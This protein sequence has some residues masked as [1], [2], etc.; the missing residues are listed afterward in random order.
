MPNINGWQLTDKLITIGKTNNEAEPLLDALRLLKTMEHDIKTSVVDKRGETIR[1][2]ETPEILRIHQKSAEI[3][4]V[5][6]HMLAESKGDTDTLVAIDEDS[7]HFDAP[8]DFDAFC[9]YMELDRDLER[10]F[11]FPRRPQLLPIVKALERLERG[12]LDILTIS[13]PPGTG[14]ALADD[15]PVL[16]RN[17]WKNHGDLVVGDE[18]VGLDGEWKKVLAVHPKCMLDQRV[19]FSNGESI[20]CH[21]AHE[22]LVFDRGRNREIQIETQALRRVPLESGVP[23]QRGHRY[24]FQLPY[25]PPLMGDDKELPMDPYTLGVWLGDGTGTAPTI[26][27]APKDKAVIDRIVA[28]GA[29]IQWTTTHKTTGVLYFG[30][31]FQKKLKSLG[32]CST[33]HRLPKFIPEAYIT[34][35]IWQRLD[36]LA[37]LLDSDGCLRES[38]YQFSTCE[39][40]LRDTFLDLIA[41]FG[42]RACV[43]TEPPRT[44]TSGI[45]GRRPVYIISFTPDIVL[46]CTLQRKRNYRPRP[47]RK[48][49]IKSIKTITPVRGNC[50]T[51]EGGMYRVG[52]TQLPTHNSETALFYLAWIGG[53]SPDLANLIVSHSGNIIHMM[54]DELKRLLY[55]GDEYRFYDV[56]PNAPLKSCSG[57]LLTIDLE[58]R[59]RFPTFQFT[60]LGSSNAGRV[61]AMNLLYC[62]DLV[63]GI[64]QAMNPVALE[65]LWRQYTVDAKQRGIGDKVKELHIATRWSQSDVIGRL[66][67]INRHNPRALFLNYPAMDADGHSLFDYPY[68]LGY[69]DAKLKEL[70][71]NMDDAAYQSLYMGEPYERDGQLY[72]KDELR[73]Y[74][75]L[76]DREPDAIIAVCDTKTTGQD[77]CVLPIVYV[78]GSDYYVDDVVCE[79]YSPDIVENSVVQK[80]LQHKVQQAQFESNVAGGKMAQVVQERVNQAGGVTSITTKW[81]QSHK[82]TKIQVNAPWVKLH[83]LFRDDSI[84]GGKEWSEYR[85]FL[86]QL[87]QYS[88]KGKNR[89]DDVPDAMAQLALYVTKQSQVQKVKLVKRWF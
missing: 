53:R 17:G 88:L 20:T 78:Y 8:H 57:D 49:A 11:Y 75:Q 38:K 1:I 62:D 86:R 55:S 25:R 37:G 74:L 7:L 87:M 15:T 64:E 85:M 28:N 27:C 5:V 14:K 19:T 16:T 13:M 83:C 40:T 70:Q 84:I 51:V 67:A 39:E 71:S 34:A 18:V 65:K 66:E 35:S 68:G 41:T 58:R 42:W 31:D 69:N 12:E 48:V 63:T 29:K 79:N 52:R 2:F 36:L 22:W 82:E 60:S 89:H 24:R 80:L 32:M 47:Q 61:R 26:C 3:R 59:R 4:D 44:S 76:P 9:Q 30:F 72:G 45:T 54:Y 21:N 56:F 6:R 50:I 73:R 23:D 10:Q 33:T 77:Y 81:T 43:H 46:P